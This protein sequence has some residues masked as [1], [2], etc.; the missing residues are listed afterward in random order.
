MKTAIFIDGAYLDKVMQKEFGFFLDYSKLPSVLAPGKE[1]LRTYYYN[2]RPYQSPT[3]TEEERKRMSD[4]ER[5]YSYLQK[6]P[7]YQLQFGKLAKR[8][9]GFEQ[10][11]VDTLL[12]IDIV[13]LAATR[14]ISDAILVA[15]DSD[16]VP[17]VLRVKSLGVNI[18]LFHSQRRD[19]YHDD[20][21]SA[22][23]EREPLIKTLVEQ[24]HRK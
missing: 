22:C 14:M 1:L 11:G 12:S 15:G 16:F 20:L 5:F 2:C 8:P 19:S 21:W 6:L 3:P 18:K 4:T 24:L 23:D 7:K 10:K 13:E 9:D 17:A